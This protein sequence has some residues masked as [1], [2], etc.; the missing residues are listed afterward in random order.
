M[1]SFL[2]FVFSMLVFGDTTAEA[3]M[4]NET[5]TTK[6]YARSSDGCSGSGICT[7]TTT[8]PSSSGYI[9]THWTLDRQNQVLT[10]QIPSSEL[11]IAPED[12]VAQLMDG[13]FIMSKSFHFPLEISYAL[14]SDA[15]IV[16][17]AGTYT[18][19]ENANGYTVTFTL[20]QEMQ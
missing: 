10:M 12:M 13:M 20:N 9:T 8:S 4:T 16:I 2:P 1:K 15:E 19:R 17:A 5:I 6:T 11:S 18:A 3:I 7:V 14:G